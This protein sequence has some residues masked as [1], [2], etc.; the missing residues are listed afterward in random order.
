MAGTF[1]IKRRKQ[2]TH[3]PHGQSSQRSVLQALGIGVG[4]TSPHAAS[5]P[6][7]IH[8]HDPA[9]D[10]LLARAAAQGWSLATGRPLPP[11]MRVRRPLREPAPMTTVARA[12]SYGG[13]DTYRPVQAILDDPAL[14]TAQ[15]RRALHKAG[16]HGEVPAG[17]IPAARL[18]HRPPAP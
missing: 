12:L 10:A 2:D 5:K 14:T 18:T 3:K 1:S 11:H 7:H 4:R 13:P 17:Y 8:V 6:G 16:S 15:R 9:A